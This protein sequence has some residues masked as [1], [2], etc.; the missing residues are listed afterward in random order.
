LAQLVA[1]A[2][3][4]EEA[5]EEVVGHHV[6]ALRAVRVEQPQALGALDVE[7]VLLLLVAEDLLGL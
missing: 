3:A 2:E 4:S 1:A 5:S 6:I 7:D